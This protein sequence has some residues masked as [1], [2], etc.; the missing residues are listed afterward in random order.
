MYTD[1]LKRSGRFLE[2]IIGWKKNCHILKGL[3]IKKKNKRHK[4]IYVIN[5]TFML[6][7]QEIVHLKYNSKRKSI[8]T[9]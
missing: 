3:S 6:S 5:I 2:R 7:I 4:Y 1:L 9:F 8:K